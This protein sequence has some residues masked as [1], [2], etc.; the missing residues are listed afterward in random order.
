MKAGSFRCWHCD[1]WVSFS[2]FIGTKHRNHCPFCLWS[3]HVDLEKPGDRN[4][5]CQGEMKPIGLTFKQGGGELMIIHQCTNPDCGKISI[6]RIAGDDSSSAI[7]NI[8]KESQTLSPDLTKK[9]KR[10]NIRLLTKADEKQIRTQLFGE[11][12]LHDCAG[13]RT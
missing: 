7:L 9:L 11:S 5:T 8:F 6:N 12:N 2:S 10:G 1:R 3:K 13:D 4:S